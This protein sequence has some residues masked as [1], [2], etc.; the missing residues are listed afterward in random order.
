MH[1]ISAN[2]GCQIRS[3]WYFH[4][5]MSVDEMGSALPSP[6]LLNPSRNPIYPQLVSPSW[7]TSR[8]LKLSLWNKTGKQCTD[9]RSSRRKKTPICPTDS[10]LQY[11]VNRMATHSES[12]PSNLVSFSALTIHLWCAATF[13][14][15]DSSSCPHSLSL[16]DLQKPHLRC[17]P[18]PFFCPTEPDMIF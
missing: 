12:L 16:L 2:T 9:R 6:H 8:V 18:D 11:F 17:L 4:R 1:V 13:W 10:P 14:F 7:V 15:S 3:R 5:E